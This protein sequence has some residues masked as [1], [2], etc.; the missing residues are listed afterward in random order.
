MDELDD[1]LSSE[2]EM[3]HTLENVAPPSSK[4]KTK[5]ENSMSGKKSRRTMSLGGVLKK[6]DSLQLAVV[7]YEDTDNQIVESRIQFD[8]KIKLS[9]DHDGLAM[10]RFDNLHNTPI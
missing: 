9:D 7:G 4:R 1:I 10:V 5:G 6:P 2:Q 8:N 3:E